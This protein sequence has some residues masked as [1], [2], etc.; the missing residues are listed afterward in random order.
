MPMPGFRWETWIMG[1]A[2]NIVAGVLFGVA[3]WAAGILLLTFPFC[4]SAGVRKGTVSTVR[5]FLP[6]VSHSA[7]REIGR[8][9]LGVF[10]GL[11]LWAGYYILKGEGVR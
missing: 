3:V 8:W 10:G 6:R 7:A 5:F 2:P 1:Y 11:C 4:H 9:M